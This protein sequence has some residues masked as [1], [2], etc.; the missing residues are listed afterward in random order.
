[1]PDGSPAEPERPIASRNLRA[2][3]P[4]LVIAVVGGKLC[5]AILEWPDP[6]DG[7]IVLGLLGLLACAYFAL[8]SR[9]RGNDRRGSEHEE[10]GA[11]KTVDGDHGPGAGQ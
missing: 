9:S 4:A 2:F 5:S 10:F 11:T 7:F 1:M 6:A 8:A 3:G